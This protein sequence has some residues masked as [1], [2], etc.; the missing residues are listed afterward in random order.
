M[1]LDLFWERIFSEE[2]PDVRAAWEALEPEEQESVRQLLRE[3]A[4]DEGR[5]IEQRRAAGFAL[6]I[7]GAAPGTDGLP[8]GAL[9]FARELARD[10]GIRLRKVEGLLVATLKK[11]GT[12]VTEFD[13]EADRNISQAIRERY[14][15]TVVGPYFLPWTAT[16][17]RF[18]RG[19]G[20]PSYGFS[21]FLIT[22]T[23]TMGIA[24]A[25]ERM[26]LPGFVDGVAIYRR[27]IR[28]LAE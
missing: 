25:N 20:V 11:D 12:L 4:A 28:E 9:A 13:L 22:V 10:A 3:I 23:D 15:K 21:P 2:A 17:S 8:P 26:P 5:V 1:N 16:D 18:F 24:R 7:V 14:P 27:L 6:E 19:I